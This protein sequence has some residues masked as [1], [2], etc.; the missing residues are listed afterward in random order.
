MNRCPK[1]GED[2]PDGV[3]VCRMCGVPVRRG[4]GLFRRLL[5]LLGRA[6]AP[7][8]EQYV[9]TQTRVERGPLGPVEGPRVPGDVDLQL[10]DAEEAAQEAGMEDS[11]ADVAVRTSIARLTGSITI[12]EDGVTKTYGS[13]E[14]MPPQ[15]RERYREILGRHGGV[16]APEG[17]ITVEVNGVRRTYRRLEDVPPE[18][19]ARVEAIRSSRQ[20]PS[21]NS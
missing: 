3:G 16:G 14:E 9:I 5:G 2:Y 4:K 7:S 1:C 15:L 11:G 19:R 17:Q 12:T 13:W 10:I 20:T 8:R 18:I 6:L 21:E